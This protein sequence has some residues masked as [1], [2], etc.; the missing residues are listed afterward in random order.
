[1]ITLPGN[2]EL[3][4]VSQDINA[5]LSRLSSV[6]ENAKT[7]SLENVSIAE[8]LHQSAT[9]IGEESQNTSKTITTSHKKSDDVLNFLNNSV[10]INE[11]SN[12]QVN[13]AYTYV[14]E[15]QSHIS[16]MVER[17]RNN[18]IEEEN[19]AEKIVLLSEQTQEV[20]MVL[21]IISEIAEQ[22][23]LL[24]LNAAIE[25]ARAGEHG[26]GFAVVAD[27][28]R[29]LAE[30]TQRSLSDINSTINVIVQSATEASDLM[31]KNAKETQ[32]LIG[33]SNE[34]D[35]KIEQISSV[36]KKVQDSSSTNTETMMKTSDKIIELLELLKEV[37]NGA[38]RNINSVE[39]IVVATNQ[40]SHETIKLNNQLE[41][42]QTHS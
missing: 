11:S 4:K 18:A 25:A 2:D 13:E 26:R 31:R 38:N 17:F 10:T 20:K 36:M 27:E 24:A 7:A 42:F 5:L 23:N 28:V 32:A 8:E 19:V 21:T 33:V 22:T 9:I 16:M 12:T 37:S 15:T 14:D 34:V 39:Q 6:L 3:N 35:E 40:L 41:Q 30:R 29:K 1:M